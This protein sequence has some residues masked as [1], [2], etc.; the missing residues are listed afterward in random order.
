MPGIFNAAIFNNAIFNTD[1]TGDGVILLGGTPA[2]PNVNPN[3]ADFYHYDHPY[4]AYKR[5]Q[6]ALA[7]KQ[8]AIIAMRLEA[9]ENI[10]RQKEIKTNRDK[11]SARQLK[12]LERQQEQL[13][14][15]IAEAM[16][17]LEKRQLISR[18]NLAILVL[19]AAYPYINIS[20]GNIPLAINPKEN[21]YGTRH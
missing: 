15:A 14:I 20:D 17:E 8:E 10:L 1:G 7:E 12:A 9:Q 4:E 21:Y 13:T 6:A 5:E 18:N 3:A 11:Q 19:V 2:G 16:V